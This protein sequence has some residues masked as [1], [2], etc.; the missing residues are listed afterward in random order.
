MAV[1]INPQ[2]GD[3]RETKEVWIRGCGFGDV[4]HAGR[5]PDFLLFCALTFL[6]ILV[7]VSFGT[8]LATVVECNN[9]LITLLAPK[10][11]GVFLCTEEV[12]VDV[13]V[14]VRGSV[15]DSAISYTYVNTQVQTLL[16]NK[17]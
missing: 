1:A 13:V 11:P 17:Q 9:D 16:Q 10:L 7:S 14:S 5:C 4:G 8:S 15:V 6:Y 2:R 3:F 12:T